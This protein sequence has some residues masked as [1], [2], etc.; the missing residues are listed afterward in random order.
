MIINIMDKYDYDTSIE[1]YNNS[2]MVNML[3]E[4]TTIQ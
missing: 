4:R 2:E 1:A 3:K